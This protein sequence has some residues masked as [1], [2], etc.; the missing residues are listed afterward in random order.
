MITTCR[1]LDLTGESTLADGVGFDLEGLAP[2][3]TG[4]ERPESFSALPDGGPADASRY[5]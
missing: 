4:P 2:G 1:G 3:P 5:R